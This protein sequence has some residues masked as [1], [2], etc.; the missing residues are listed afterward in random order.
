MLQSLTSPG[1]LY[2]ISEVAAERH[3]LVA[4][5]HTMQLTTVQLI[6]IPLP[7]QQHVITVVTTMRVKIKQ[8][9]SLFVIISANMNR[10]KFCKVV[11]QHIL[12]EVADFIPASIAIHL[13]I[14]ES[15]N[16][17]NRSPFA[18]VITKRPR[19]CFFDSRYT[20]FQFC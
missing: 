7:C 16:Y 6:D 9:R 2:I 3:E 8:L 10:F 19:R 13:G 18:K 11:R 17:Y 5:L 12:G 1:E 14:P 15:K 4:P 20:H